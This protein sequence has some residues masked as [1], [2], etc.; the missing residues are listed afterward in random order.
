MSL[1]YA[2]WGDQIDPQAHH[3]M[4][5]ACELPVAHAAALMP[6]AHVG[7]GLPIGG[8]LAVKNAV[9]PYAVGVDIACRVMLSV[10]S[11]PLVKFHKNT[12]KFE[13]AL[14]EHTYFGIGARNPNPEEHAV[15]D[16]D[17]NISP[18]ISGLKDKAWS[19]LG[20]SGSGNHFVEFGEFDLLETKGEL[21]PGKYLALVSHSGSRGA[22]AKIADHFSRRAKELHPELASYL[23][24]LA[25]LDLPGEGEEYW[26]AME[27]MGKYASASHHIIHHRL[28]RAIGTK[29]L[30][31]IENHHNYAWKETHSGVPVIVHRKGATPAGAG[32]LGYI[33]GTMV[34]PGYLVEGLG[35]AESLNSSSHGA[36]RKLSRTQAKSSTTG[37]ALKKLLA[38]HRV[39][40]MSAGLDESPHA[41][42]DIEGV[43]AAQSQLV[44]PIARF[45]PK[46]V[47]MAPDGE[48]PED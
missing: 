31:Q 45:T 26:A 22:G 14:G 8:V 11:E 7:Y 25:W 34:D 3:Q 33:P 46:L 29:A 5:N 10:L 4:K 35:K 17:W 23:Q 20:T 15:M 6:D 16:E 13:R 21:S 30:L 2:F 32:V 47:R 36:G 9:I 19:Q 27:L 12:A 44:R 24:N 42:K 18:L 28:V 39:H 43:M 38:T 40:L 41:Y 37:S 48:R 1:E